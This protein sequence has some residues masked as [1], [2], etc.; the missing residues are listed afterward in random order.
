MHRRLPI[1]RL[2][3]AALLLVPVLPAAPAWAGAW[4]VP[5]N[6]WYVEYFWRYFY[7]KHQYDASGDSSRRPTTG[8]FTDIRNE[9]KLEY[10]LTD[11]WNLLASAPYISSHYRDD[12][13][14]LLRTGVGDINLRTKFRVWNRPT[15]FKN[16]TVVSTQF[17]VKIPDAYDVN[18]DPL[19]DGQWDLESRVMVSQ[20]WQFRAPFGNPK[21]PLPSKDWWRG[22]DAAPAVPAPTREAAIRDAVLL[23]ELVQRGTALHEAGRTAEAVPF[24]QAALASEPEHEIVLTLVLNHAARMMA[25]AEAEAHGGWMLAAADRLELVQEEPIIPAEA[26][27]LDGVAFVNFE[28]GY[29]ARAEDPANEV[30]LFAEVGFT[31]MKRLMLIGSLDAVVG[32]RH[33]GEDIENF[34]KWGVRAVINVMGDGFASIFKT[35]GEP[36]VNIEIGYNDIFAGRNTADAWELFGK[37]GVFF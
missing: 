30:P 32:D 34:A 26:T 29:T 9:L 25:Q 12:N 21:L 3:A 22:A 5:K 35:T 15:M 33:T 10:G 6:R 11:W 1:F 27:D 8:R 23:A 7:S 13:V 19:G 20:A 31:P 14:D 16:P 24:L 18:Q 28:T 36:T 37:V 2:L 4:T 17:G